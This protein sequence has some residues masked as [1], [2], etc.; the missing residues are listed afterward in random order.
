MAH[1]AKITPRH[2]DR[3]LCGHD[4]TKASAVEHG[5]PG[6]VDRLM[7]C[8]CGWERAGRSSGRLVAQHRAHSVRAASVQKSAKG[9]RS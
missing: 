2:P 8:A 9:G 6:Q 4:L 3:T 7:T 1:D 5:C